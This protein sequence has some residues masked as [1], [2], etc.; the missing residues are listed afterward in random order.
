MNEMLWS[1]RRRKRM[2]SSGTK[3][4]KQNSPLD[5]SVPAVQIPLLSQRVDAV[6]YF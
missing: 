6:R 1:N 2:Y 3:K 5:A 4:Q